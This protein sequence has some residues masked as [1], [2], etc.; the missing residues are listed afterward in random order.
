MICFYSVLKLSGEGS[1]STDLGLINTPYQIA[2]T[3]GNFLIWK[4]LV[5]S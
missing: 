5:V 3:I 2:E 4:T 1:P